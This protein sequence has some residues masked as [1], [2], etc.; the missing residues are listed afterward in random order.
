MYHKETKMMTM[1]NAN[2]QTKTKRHRK[3]CF[4]CKFAVRVES[5]Y[6]LLCWQRRIEP[7]CINCTPAQTWKSA[8]RSTIGPSLTVAGKIT[9]KEQT[10]LH[11]V[12]SETALR[13]S[14]TAKIVFGD[15]S[16]EIVWWVR[17]VMKTA[18][19]KEEI[20]RFRWPPLVIKYTALP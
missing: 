4:R 12:L 3:E 2:L 7:L 14:T 17:T 1:H 13:H 6:T 9:T 8:H 15:R 20:A 18:A 5:L 11:S 10:V 16:K 19:H